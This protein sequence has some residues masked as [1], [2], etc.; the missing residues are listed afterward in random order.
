GAGCQS[1]PLDCGP[2]RSRLF[3]DAAFRPAGVGRV[4]AHGLAVRG[5]RSARAPAVELRHLPAYDASHHPSCRGRGQGV[6][7]LAAR[8]GIG[9][10]E[11]SMIIEE[12]RAVV[13]DWP[14][15]AR[16]SGVSVASSVLIRKAHERAWAD[17]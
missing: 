14:G 12:T 8:H 2:A 10:R 1:A 3:R 9:P 17:F 13:V 11:A 4:S 5:H 15:F 16:M 6:E 7:A